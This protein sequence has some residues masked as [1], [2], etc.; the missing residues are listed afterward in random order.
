MERIIDT[1][2]WRQSWEADGASFSVLNYGPYGIT[3]ERSSFIKPGP[4]GPLAGNLSKARFAFP[5]AVF[6]FGP[7]HAWAFADLIP[8]ATM[9]GMRFVTTAGHPVTNYELP[10]GLVGTVL[11]WT[12]DFVSLTMDKYIEDLDEWDNELSWTE[13]TDADLPADARIAFLRE[14]EPL[15]DQTPLDPNRRRYAVHDQR[16]TR[17]A[18]ILRDTYNRDAS[19]ATLGGGIQGLYVTLPG[20][21]TVTVGTADEVWG[22]DLDDVEGTFSGEI[23]ESTDVPEN[24]PATEAAK[25][26]NAMI[27][28]LHNRHAAKTATLPDDLLDALRLFNEAAQHLALVWRYRGELT[29]AYPF[30]MS[31]DELAGEINDWADRH[32]NG[33]DA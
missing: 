10:E 29:E 18:E 2:Q 24:A 8:R 19:W 20:G 31:F 11:E 33:P 3:V 22:A 1:Y 14:A 5:L 4:T 6:A 26:I 13:D 25:A 16:I 17:I 12:E 27:A 9:Y 28:T 32:L 30:E 7:S 21:L 15:A 23:Y